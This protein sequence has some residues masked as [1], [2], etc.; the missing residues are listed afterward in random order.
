MD[1][2]ELIRTYQQQ[3]SITVSLTSVVHWGFVL[4]PHQLFD[5]HSAI[6]EVDMQAF[7]AWPRDRVISA[8]SAY[9]MSLC[10]V[11]ILG[12]A[13]GILLGCSQLLS[14]SVENLLWWT[15]SFGA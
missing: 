14:P 6:S 10:F 12:P 1:E 2:S 8:L 4:K 7:H 15:W 9:P 3:V 11:P 5:D 13:Q